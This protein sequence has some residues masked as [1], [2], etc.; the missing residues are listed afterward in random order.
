MMDEDRAAGKHIAGGLEEK[1]GELKGLALSYR[2]WLERCQQ[3]LDR[4][5]SPADTLPVFS[6]EQ[7]LDELNL[8]ALNDKKA[9][10]DPEPL[11]AGMASITRRHNRRVAREVEVNP[12][13]QATVTVNRMNLLRQSHLSRFEAGLLELLY[14]ARIANTLSRLRDR[15]G[16]S[17]RQLEQRSA[18]SFS[19]LSQIERLSGSLPSS[20]ILANLDA[21]ISHRK[22]E[23]GATL[24]EQRGQYDTGMQTLQ[25]EEARFGGAWNQIMGGGPYQTNPTKKSLTG[26]DRSMQTG[27]TGTRQTNL[28]C[29]SEREER[30]GASRPAVSNTVANGGREDSGD[31]GNDIDY[32]DDDDIGG[33]LSAGRRAEVST[34]ELCDYFID[35]SPGLQRTVLRL[36]KDLAR[37]DKSRRRGF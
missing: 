35:L 22:G 27:Q 19:Y 28:G 1:M 9:G 37:N 2:E 13:A 24:L 23:P 3:A 31:N 4:G 12:G 30:P 7:F 14:K 33:V 29:T 26:Q 15:Q 32:I 21:V 11:L 6:A 16:I 17:L 8:S 25:E 18:V 10:T 36:V 5:D 20:E 34:F